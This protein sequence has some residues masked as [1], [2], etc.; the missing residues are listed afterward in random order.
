MGIVKGKLQPCA[1]SANCV[2]SEYPQ[3]PAAMEAIP[4]TDS[5]AEAM[6]KLTQIVSHM[7]RSRVVSQ[8]DG[9]LHAEFRSALFRFADDVEFRIDQHASV[10]HFRSASRIG[11]FD[12]GANR[13][14]MKEI[15]AA[16]L[17]DG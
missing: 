17:S 13:A 4:C 7:P 3:S 16:F 1:N 9:Y 8:T 12:L 11:L 2:C 14:R 10:I 5:P 15:T 6:A